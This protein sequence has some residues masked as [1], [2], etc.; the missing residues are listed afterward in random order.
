MSDEKHSLNTFDKVDPCSNCCHSCTNDFNPLLA[1]INLEDRI[2][3]DDNRNEITYKKG[4]IIFRENTFPSG[5]FC[6]R[7]GKVMVTKTDEFGNTIVI[8]MHKGVNFIGVADHLMGSPYQS[9]CI[10]LSDVKACMIKSSAVEDLITKN[11]GFARRL[12]SSLASDYHQSSNRLLAI[13][14]KNMYARIADA[15]LELL[16]VFGTDE[17]G[18][19]DVYLKRSEIA[20]I[21]NMN[22]TNVIRHLSALAKMGAIKLIGKKILVQDKEILIRESNSSY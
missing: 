11:P 4:S 6:L 10:A 13:T 2:K 9:T 18:C 7:E 17:E 12:L 21:C 5:L 8:N 15:L 1:G 16:S 22:E 20:Q 3:L 19:I 14:K